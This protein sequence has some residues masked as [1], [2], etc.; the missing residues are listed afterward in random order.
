MERA[1]SLMSAVLDKNAEFYIKNVR[2]QILR[3]LD[4]DNDGTINAEE[5]APALIALGIDV[6]D[7]KLTEMVAKMDQN[8]SGSVDYAAFMDKLKAGLNWKCIQTLFEASSVTT[9]TAHACSIL[10][11]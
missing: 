5:M 11:S 2:K 10:T 1:L 9:P 6:G 3:F 4:A 8:G 7:A